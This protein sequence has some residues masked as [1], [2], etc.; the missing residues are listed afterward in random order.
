MS[1]FPELGSH[2]REKIK[3]EV[4]LCSYATKVDLKGATD[5]RYI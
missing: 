1:N 5:V 4:D 2:T 3:V